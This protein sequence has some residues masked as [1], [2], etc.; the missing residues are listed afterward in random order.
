MVRQRNFFKIRERNAQSDIPAIACVLPVKHAPPLASKRTE[1]HTFRASVMTVAPT[2]FIFGN[3]RSECLSEFI[4]VDIFGVLFEVSYV[5][6]AYVFRH[7]YVSLD[8]VLIFVSIY[9]SLLQGSSG[10]NGH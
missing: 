8:L 10:S 4:F 6:R 7:S 5:E 1:K 2:Q 9:V 3:M